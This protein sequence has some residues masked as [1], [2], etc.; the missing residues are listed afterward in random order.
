[1]SGSVPASIDDMALL[2]GGVVW[3]GSDSHYPEEA[4]PHP[5]T[6]L[7]F[8][9]D[10]FTVTNSQFA[11][12]VEA[13][14]HVSV[15]ETM[16]QLRDYPSADP[17][18]LMDGSI[19]F[20]GTEDQQLEDWRQW[21]RYVP[22]ACWHSPSGPDSDWRARPDDPVVHVA[23][24]DAAA[25]ASWAGKRLPTEAEWEFAA[26]GGLEGQDFAWGTE[27]E[28]EG[29]VLAN[30]WRGPFP[31]ARDNATRKTTPVGSYP[32]NGFGLFDMIGNV[33][34]WTSDDFTMHRGLGGC[35][36]PDASASDPSPKVLKGGSWLC[37][38][39]YCQRYRPAARSGL[40][41]ETSSC[42]VGFRC[43][44]DA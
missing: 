43:A 17:Q 24:S 15:A 22:G 42:H 33:W 16:P 35:C 23:H 40:A 8:R 14:G 25:Y 9:I 12:F 3:M 39:S 6:V 19:C 7:P 44:A 21:W 10:R 31:T 18:L 26:R 11:A 27:L 38:E 30:Y 4:P 36:Q 28:P 29:R 34:E 5:A 13:T 32:P 41:I 20:C 1:M 37:A 2:A